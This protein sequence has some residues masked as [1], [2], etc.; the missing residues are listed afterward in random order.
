MKT[1]DMLARQLDEDISFELW[2]VGCLE[3]LES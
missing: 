2:D 3:L 1:G